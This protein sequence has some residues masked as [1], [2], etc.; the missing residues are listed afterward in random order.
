GELEQAEAS[1]HGF[2]DSLAERRDAVAQADAH[3]ESL[4]TALDALRHQRETERQALLE[5]AQKQSALGSRAAVLESRWQERHGGWLDS[6]AA[7]ERARAEQQQA[8][9]RQAT[10]QQRHDRAAEL[11]ATHRQRLAALHAERATLQA[12]LAEQ[13]QTIAQLREERASLEARQVLLEELDRRQEGLGLGVR[14]LL[15]LSRRQPDGPFQQVLGQVSELVECEL[16]NAAL[17]DVALGARAQLV[18]V[19]DTGLLVDAVRAGTT[20]LASRVGFLTLPQGGVPQPTRIECLTPHE[21]PDLS[22]YPGVICRA[23]ELLR[24]VATCPDL[25]ALLLADTWLV[26]SLEEATP[27][28]LVTQGRCRFVTLQG[29]LLEANGTLYLG[30]LPSDT[31]GLSRKT[32]LRGVKTDLQRCDRQLTAAERNQVALTERL[33]R[34]GDEERQ[35]QFDGDVAAYELAESRTAAATA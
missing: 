13:R 17:V 6:Q 26:R 2:Q 25:P 19:A 32:E 21:V 27:L 34:L 8:A 12:D 18:V 20:R 7:V 15:A 30:S 3:T 1:L 22:G 9:D 35:L 33:T 14:D 16:E 11:V 28:P 29:E 23:D 24:P 4:A 5:I 31:A 10:E